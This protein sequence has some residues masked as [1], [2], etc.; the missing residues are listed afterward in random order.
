MSEFEC[1]VS[2]NGKTHKPLLN[3]VS[4][5]INQ[6][7]NDLNSMLKMRVRMNIWSILHVM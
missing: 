4:I 7:G 3:A 2:A 5:S 6:I 1:E